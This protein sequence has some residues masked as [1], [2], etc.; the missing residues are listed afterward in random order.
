VGVR[1]LFGDFNNDSDFD[2]NL[3][4]INA[5]STIDLSTLGLG[6]PGDIA[7]D[8]GDNGRPFRDYTLT[9][10]VQNTSGSEINQWSFS[11]DTWYAD[12]DS[13]NA[14]A[15]IL[16]STDNV[17]FTSIDSYTTTATPVA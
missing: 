3:G 1:T 4:T 10:R 6:S 15:S 16:W 5:V 9:L 11:L 8:I 14:T 13:N 17:N 12:D 7:W 2:D